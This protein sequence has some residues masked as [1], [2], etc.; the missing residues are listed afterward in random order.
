MPIRSRHSLTVQQRS[1]HCHKSLLS[2]QIPNRPVRLALS[3][4]K[5]STDF[6]SNGAISMSYV[7][8]D[9]WGR[10]TTST[11]CTLHQLS[12]FIGKLRPSVAHDLIRSFSKPSDLVIDPFAGS[13]TV[14]LEAATSGRNVFASD[15]NP[16]AEIL[17]RAKL[18]PPGD[19]VDALAEADTLLCESQD[20]ASRLDLADV[21]EWV[22]RFFH[23]KTLRE[24]IAL[25][26]LCLQRKKYFILACLLGIL[27][28]QRPGFLS[29]PASHLV[30]YL[31]T[32]NFPRAMYPHLYA[33][34][35]VRER[36]LA[37]ILRA[38]RRPPTALNGERQFRR[39]SV[40]NLTV[41]RKFDCMITSPPYM[42]ALDYGRDNRLR[43]WFVTRS[44]HSNIDAANTRDR[45]TF[46]ELI[47]ATAQH[48][49]SHLNVGG[50]A[51]LVIGER[52]NRKYYARP[53]AVASQILQQRCR[54][55]SLQ[56]VLTD[57]IPDVRRSRREYRGVRTEHVLVFKKQPVNVA[58][59]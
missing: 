28:H 19:C 14:A 59:R 33:Y 11:E 9:K 29:H 8:P 35:P 44:G 27:H 58:R 5:R 3:F 1:G 53:S 43:L 39:S 37:K 40:Q 42:N 57:E 10:C 38:F 4:S 32:K 50:H 56:S 15:I 24:A 18:A 23:P 30:P 17:C 26:D 52:T 48:I 46:E 49:S 55:L 7:N 51:V 47:E 54:T 20:M 21:P 34:R 45:A 31:R 12:P 2:R 16:Y 41:P 36:L 22:R 6:A 13:G 25:A